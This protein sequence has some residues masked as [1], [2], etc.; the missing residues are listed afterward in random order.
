MSRRVPSLLA[1]A[2]AG[3][4]LSAGTLLGGCA[5]QGAEPG[6]AAPAPPSPAASFPV[7]IGAL[8]VTQRPERIVSLSPTATEMLFALGAGPQVVAVDDQSSYPA[9]APRT[10]LSGFKPNA[11]AIAGYNPDLVV[12]S[13][14]MD[15]IVATLA[16]LRIPVFL[17]PAAKTLD[18]TYQQVAD[19]GKLTG[20]PAEAARQATR[21]KDDI[22][23]LVKD[24]PPRT[25]PLTYYYEL[26]PT[27]YSVTSKTF[28]GSLLALLG[29]RNVADAADAAGSGYPQLTAEAL[30]K[31]NPDMIFLA[32][33][34]CCRQSADTVRARPGWTGMTAVKTGQ[35]V[36]LDDDLAS[37]WGPRVVDLV[38]VMAEAVGR[39]GQS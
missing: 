15:K 36:P 29:L 31:S 23:R 11:E 16:T 19:L 7:S 9:E 32:D 28:V 18:D 27:L 17:A 25:K 10:K 2:V 39:A 34:K 26:D 14:D 21:I 37:R 30:I 6:P 35:I 12:V 20:H 5:G 13:N 3:L 4:L 24:L 38:R 1:A 22:A 8:T 33:T